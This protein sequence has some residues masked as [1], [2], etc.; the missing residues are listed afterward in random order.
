VSQLGVSPEI[1]DRHGAVSAEVARAMAAGAVARSGADLALSVTGIA[2]PDGGTP[3]KPVGLVWV[4]LAS[5]GREPGKKV[6]A[7]AFC[8]DLAWSRTREG[9]RD[10]AA[11][12]AL[13]LLRFQLLGITP[14][15][16]GWVRTT[17]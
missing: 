12:C 10:R 11:K 4:G 6:Q 2:G 8:L 16:L 9:I 5:R 17:A 7:D 14:E 1:L 3:Q 13:Q 15:E